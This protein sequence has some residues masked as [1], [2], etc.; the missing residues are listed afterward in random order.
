VFILSDG[1]RVTAPGGTTVNSMG[2]VTFP[3]YAGGTAD[4]P[5]G[6]KIELSGS[7]T[8]FGDVITA[9]DY[10]ATIYWEDGTEMSA[11]EGTRFT[12]DARAKGCMALTAAPVVPPGIQRKV[13]LSSEAK[14]IVT[15]PPVGIHYVRSGRDF[16]VRV[17]PPAGYVPVADTDR[18]TGTGQPE[19]VTGFAIGD[20]SYGIVIPDVRQEVRTVI[21][22][23]ATGPGSSVQEASTTQVW[24]YGGKLYVRTGKAHTLYIYTAAGQLCGQYALEAGEKIIAL[25][26]GFYIVTINGQRW[27]ITP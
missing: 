21:R 27:K 5:C 24:T 4:F 18:P 3:W 25:P 16:N 1:T 6:T 7:S 9:G 17:T 26:P 13:T 14:N 12:P 22:L 8:V 2:L 23:S 10:G 15:H 19:S 20:G 11:P